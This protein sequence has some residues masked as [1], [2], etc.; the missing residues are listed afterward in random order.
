MSAFLEAAKPRRVTTEQ[1]IVGVVQVDPFV[2]VLEQPRCV[3][4]SAFRKCVHQTVEIPGLHAAAF[5]RNAHWRD[6]GG[7]LCQYRD[8]LLQVREPEFTVN[9]DRDVMY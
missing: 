5:F 9:H 4:F 3:K 8:V 1:Q 7:F 2:P 6:R